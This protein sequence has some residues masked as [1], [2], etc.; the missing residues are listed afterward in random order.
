MIIDDSLKSFP[1]STVYQIVKREY[2]PTNKMV[3][4]NLTP[5]K[6]M[7][8]IP[9]KNDLPGKNV[10]YEYR[11]MKFLPLAGVAFVLAYRHYD[12][13]DTPDKDAKTTNIALGTFFLLAGIADVWISFTPVEISGTSKSL[14]MLIYF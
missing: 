5:L 11:N 6:T 3:I 14:S 9:E 12:M 4:E 7:N 10:N 13:T 1:L 2:D 8:D